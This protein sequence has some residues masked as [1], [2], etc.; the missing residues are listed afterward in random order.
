M[1]GIFCGVLSIPQNTGMNLNNVMYGCLCDQE[2]FKLG[3]IKA[4]YTWGK[5]G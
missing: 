5:M 2:L 1:W 3:P 4:T